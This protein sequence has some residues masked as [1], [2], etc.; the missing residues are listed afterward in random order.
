MGLDVK[1]QPFWFSTIP[2]GQ[3][4]L[5]ERSWS[6]PASGDQPGGGQDGPQDVQEAQDLRHLHH[7]RREENV[8]K[9]WMFDI[10]YLFVDIYLILPIFSVKYTN[11][12]FTCLVLNPANEFV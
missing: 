5:S 8:N 12:L 10:L 11:I 3:H 9:V 7:V 6:F 4:W 1:T 2:V